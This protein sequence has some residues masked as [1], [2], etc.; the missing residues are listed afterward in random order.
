MGR[1]AVALLARKIMGNGTDIPEKV[2]C[3]TELI[4]RESVAR[5]NI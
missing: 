2:L 3:E 1:A 4:V 5:V